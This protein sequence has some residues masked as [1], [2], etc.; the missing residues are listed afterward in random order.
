MTRLL[1][2]TNGMTSV[3]Y[4]CLELARRLENAGYDVLFLGPPASSDETLEVSRYE[5]FLAK[6]AQRSLLD[7]LLHLKERRHLAKESTATKSF[8][9]AVRDFK[10]DLLLLDGEM[11]EHILAVSGVGIPIVLLNS[12]VSIWRRPGLPPPHCLLQPEQRLKNRALWFSLRLWK[13]RRAWRQKIHRVGC[14]R[15]SILRELAKEASFDLRSEVDASQWLVPF[16]YR[17]FP[18]LSLHALEFEFPHEPARNVHYVGPMILRR[19]EES[20]PSNALEE[21]LSKPTQRRRI[22]VG[23]GSVFTG[24]PA[25]LLRLFGVVERRP[26]WELI[27]SLSGRVDRAA[28]GTLP[29]RIHVFD[30]VPQLRVLECVDVAITHGG[31]N[32]IDEC[33]LHSVPMLIYCGF[34][35]DMA[36]NTA[37]VVH[38]GIGLAGDRKQDDVETI[39]GRLDRLLK[40]PSFAENIERM[41]R[42]YTAYGE[43]KAA[44]NTVSALLKGQEP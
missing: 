9:R 23:F 3:V 24:D 35:T 4:P 7:R 44:E 29:E 12:F 19:R 39:C 28:L 37:R 38:H 15:L 22:Y 40:E 17:H 14:D 11:H 30:W 41:C 13:L 6:D 16:T 34:E 10:P 32:T 33:V 42:S 2:A 27:V 5:E 20:S 31:I 21:L 1:I 25:F 26:D 43:R 8:L 36:G 18:Y